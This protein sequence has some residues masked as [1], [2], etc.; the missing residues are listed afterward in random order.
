[1]L[2]F[3]LACSLHGGVYFDSKLKW[4]NS[5]LIFVIAR[6]SLQNTNFH[7]KVGRSELGAKVKYN[8]IP[9]LRKD[10]N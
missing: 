3:E 4:S 10:Q 5:L 1:M 8:K 2:H 7:L 9:N 6:I